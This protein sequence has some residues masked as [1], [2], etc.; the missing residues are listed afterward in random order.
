MKGKV[1]GV[2]SLSKKHGLTAVEEACAT[3]LE[4][5]A[6]DYRFV[7]RYLERGSQLPLSLR[8]IDPLIRP[9]AS[10]IGPVLR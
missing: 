8:Q 7:R 4:V 5:G 2:L 6:P 1:L 10:G 9:K 3:A